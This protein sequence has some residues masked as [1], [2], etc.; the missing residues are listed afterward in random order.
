MGSWGVAERIP[1]RLAATLLDSRPMYFTIP[2][3]LKIKRIETTP[4]HALA[5]IARVLGIIPGRQNQRHGFNAM[6]AWV[7]DGIK[8]RRHIEG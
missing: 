7:G 8:I 6:R 3:A 5:R 2:L 1:K 4:I